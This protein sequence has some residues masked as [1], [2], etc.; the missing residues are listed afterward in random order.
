MEHSTDIEA[1]REGH[2]E[3]EVMSADKAVNTLPPEDPIDA[4]AERKL[5]WKIDLLILPL[6]TGFYFFQSMVRSVPPP[7][8]PALHINFSL[9]LS[10]SACNCFVTLI[11]MNRAAVYLIFSV[12]R[13][14]RTWDSRVS[15]VLMRNYSLRRRS[16]PT[17]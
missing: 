12:S 14:A 11:M 16:S 4:E 8:P 7:S 13:A 2:E 9:S 15:L 6:L 10:G 17:L 5:K 3:A 1:K